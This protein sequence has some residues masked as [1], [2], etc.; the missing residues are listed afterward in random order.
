M[1]LVLRHSKSTPVECMAYGDP[2]GHLPLRE[3]IADYLGV[4]RG[5]RC[6]PMQVM[7]TT[8]SQQGLQLA[9]RVLLDPGDAVWME[10]PGYVGARQ[11]LSMAG[12]HLVP[13][14]VD[15]EGLDV[16]EGIR[17]CPNA[18]AAY[19]T[20]SHQYPLGMKMSASRRMLLLD[21]AARHGSW[22]I[23]DDY[24]SEYRFESRPIA[25]LQGLDTD[26]RVVYVGTFSKVLFPALRLG[27]VI[28]PKDL[29]A[30][31]IEVRHA[32]DIFAPTFYQ[33]VLTDFINEG[34]FA[35]H[36]RRMRML[37]MERR[38]VLVSAIRKHFDGSLEVVSADGGMH[39]VGLLPL[40]ESDTVLA[41]RAAKN[42]ISVLPLS[43]CYVTQAPRDGF[44]MGYS[45]A[46]VDEIGAGVR[47]L[48][49]ALKR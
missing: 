2:R 31:F 30:A 13:I 45:G 25:S 49:A 16:G 24:D 42:G 37:Y 32:I 44:L 19:V 20:P 35:R 22:I 14:N 1:K 39:L 21:W 11:A 33:R 15:K 36:V 47:K 28:I 41:R 7:I 10:E 48:A 40:G 18:R 17:R 12:A 38:D 6:D 27:Y 8:G 3:S 46:S 34:H 43:T 29:I 9:G 26:S 23:E 4:V 5:V